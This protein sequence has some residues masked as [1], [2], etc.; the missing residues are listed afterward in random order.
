MVLLSL[1]IVI[2]ILV[3][4]ALPIAAGVWI[5]KKLG[6]RWTV[7]IYGAFI[8]FIVQSL[9]TLFFAGFDTLSTNGTSSLNEETFRLLQVGLSVLLTA[10]FGVLARWAAMRYMKEKLDN[11]ESAYA[12]GLGYSASESIMIWGLPLLL[13]FINMLQN[14]GNE[15]AAEAWALS[16]FVPL[17]ISI[18]LITS[19]VLSITVTILVLQ[20]FKRKSGIW[21]AAAIGLEV[22]VNGLMVGLSELGLEYGWLVLAGFILMVVNL[23]IL[24][25]LNAFDFDITRANSEELSA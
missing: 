7:I 22:L 18:Q 4:I 14:I 6:V 8:Y 1:A 10:V 12:I 15:T 17:A 13:T 24:Y 16:P 11:L 23:F 3:S 25:R 19:F 20:V 21:F 5:N 9:M 2:A